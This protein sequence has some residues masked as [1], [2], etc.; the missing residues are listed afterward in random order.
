MFSM[1]DLLSAVSEEPGFEV[2]D[3]SV[4]FN[5]QANPLTNWWNAENF[6]NEKKGEQKIIQEVVLT[7]NYEVVSSDI[8]LGSTYFTYFDSSKKPIKCTIRDMRPGEMRCMGLIGSRCHDVTI[9]TENKKSF[10][11]TNEQPFLNLVYMK[12]KGFKMI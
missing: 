10:I 1:E 12:D 8:V 7:E 2:F 3:P 4:F 6:N 9:I 5:P 11:L